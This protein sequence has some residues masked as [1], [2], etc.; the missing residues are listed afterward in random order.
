MNNSVDEQKT[1]Y[2][3]AVSKTR[4]TYE[5]LME[6]INDPVNPIGSKNIYA[7]IKLRPERYSQFKYIADELAEKEEREKKEN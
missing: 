1:M 4:K 5:A 3:N 6:M 7:M 2:Y